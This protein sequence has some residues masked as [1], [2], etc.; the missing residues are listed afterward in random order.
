[1][2]FWL[3]VRLF[4]YFPLS[5]PL[6]LLRHTYRKSNDYVDGLGAGNYLLFYDEDGRFSFSLVTKQPWLRFGLAWP[7]WLKK[8]FCGLCCFWEKPVFS[9]DALCCSS[10][11]SSAVRPFLVYNWQIQGLGS[12]LP[13]LL[14]L[15]FA[16]IIA[17]SVT[18]LIFSN[19]QARQQL[20]TMLAFRLLWHSFHSHWTMEGI[21]ISFFFGHKV[22]DHMFSTTVG[23]G[24]TSDWF[25]QFYFGR[26]TLQGEAACRGSCNFGY[27]LVLTCRSV[28]PL[29]FSVLILF[30]LNSSVF[31]L[32][33]WADHGRFTVHGNP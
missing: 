29:D 26:T 23:Q 22:K 5:Y 15:S 21:Q 7:W 11:T 12:Y 8:S 30:K 6:A 16:L 9:A 2:Y 13:L 33:L 24:G 19:T 10:F 17:S 1:M 3:V 31:I 18:D 25:P 14:I 4:F 27:H 32:S 20:Y 28:D